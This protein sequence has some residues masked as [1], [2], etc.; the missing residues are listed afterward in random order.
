MG[1]TKIDRCQ[2]HG[3]FESTETST[4]RIFGSTWSICPL[5]EAENAKRREEE[6]LRVAAKGRQD[7]IEVAHIPLRFRGKSLNDYEAITTGQ[8]RALELAKD[9]ASR[10]DAHYEVG[11]S[12]IFT[13][14]LGTGK[15]HLATGILQE[16]IAV[17][18]SDHDGWS[19][20]KWHPVR[21]TTAS[22][23][24]RT[25]RETW[26]TRTNEADALRKFVR[27]H[28]LVVDEVGLQF[29]SDSERTQLG[30]IFD[31]RYQS[32]MPTIVITNCEKSEIS[33]YIGERAVDRLRENGGLMAVLDW[34]SHR[35]TRKITQIA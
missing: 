29:G 5:C 21:Y 7:R 14:K 31:L 25:L 11:R 35:G 8:K 33:R 2:V 34:E 27:P 13:G 10:F 6:S 19:G 30:E 23:I 17:P 1:G 12:L 9:Y 26:S 24:I 22:E 20:R 4:H 32:M 15:T 3:E 28:L 16:I 18:F